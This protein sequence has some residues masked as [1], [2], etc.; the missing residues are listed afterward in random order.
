MSARFDKIL[1]PAQFEQ[2]SAASVRFAFELA[3]PHS[4]LYLLHVIP[5]GA[6]AGH[7]STVELAR[8][9]LEDFAREQP[10]GQV[11]PELLVRSGNPGEIIVNLANELK[12]DIIV[13]ATHG[14]KG[15]AR[16]LLGSV[17]ERVVRE[18]RPPVL[19]LRPAIPVQP[20]SA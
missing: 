17:A 1:C 5:E 12:V 16:L 13:M 8:E 6:D 4:R 20:K 7:S 14:H 10:A 3:Q 19:T 2:N 18:A 9:C 11:K 15:L